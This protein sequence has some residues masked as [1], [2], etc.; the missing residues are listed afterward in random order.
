MSDN[1]TSHSIG[2]GGGTLGVLGIV[3]TIAKLCGIIDWSWWI[4]LMPIYL[5][6]V[7]GVF[8]IVAMILLWIVANMNSPSR[9]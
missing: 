1:R 8:A 6:I 2:C 5:P 3:F 7:I 9:Y 4:V